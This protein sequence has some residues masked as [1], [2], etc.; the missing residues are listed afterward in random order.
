VVAGLS[1]YK[2]KTAY[3]RANKPVIE[4]TSFGSEDIAPDGGAVERPPLE[5]DIYRRCKTSASG[6]DP[7]AVHGAF[8]EHPHTTVDL[9][10]TFAPI[11]D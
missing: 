9:S 6:L 7:E 10:M 11:D 3:L 8:D 1:A 5:H 4:Y 2:S